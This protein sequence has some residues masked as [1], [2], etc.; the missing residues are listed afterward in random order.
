MTNCDAPLAGENRMAQLSP[1]HRIAATGPGRG[2]EALSWR[3]RE[4]LARIDEADL[5]ARIDQADAARS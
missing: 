1:L 3:E 5:L 4:L 2:A